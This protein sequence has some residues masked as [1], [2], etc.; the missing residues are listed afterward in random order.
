LLQHINEE[1]NG[2]LPSACFQ[3]RS[4]GRGGVLDPGQLCRVEGKKLGVVDKR[5]IF[6]EL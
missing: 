2:I 5:L 6:H 3:F 4:G 1:V